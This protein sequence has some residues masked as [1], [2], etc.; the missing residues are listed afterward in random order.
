MIVELAGRGGG[1]WVTGCWLPIDLL[2]GLGQGKGN[3]MNHELDEVDMLDQVSLQ[4]W[5]RPR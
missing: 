3:G 5:F 4:Q 1:G 2:L